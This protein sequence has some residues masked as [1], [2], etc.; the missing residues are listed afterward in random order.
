MG[1]ATEFID[2]LNNDEYKEYRY[3]TIDNYLKVFKEKYKREIRKKS[4]DKRKKK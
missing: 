1:R 4:D 2:F 3:L